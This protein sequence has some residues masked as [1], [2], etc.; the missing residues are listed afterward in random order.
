MQAVANLKT[1]LTR[2]N[3]EIEQVEYN[4]ATA[5]NPKIQDIC[6]KQLDKL[7]VEKEQILA[8][9]MEKD[10]EILNL[11]DYVSF[12]LGLKDNMLKLWKLATLT[13]KKSI[14]NL[15]F[16]EG[17]VYSK[18]NDDIEPLSKNEFLFLFDLKS[19]CC[20]DTKNGQTIISEDLSA[21]AP[22]LGLEPRTP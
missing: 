22:L 7:E 2:K 1:N 4:L 3:V 16:P 5:S 6:S 17:I 18:E 19:V 14:Q 13:N 8:E 9:L 10:K 20:G 15:I 21:S 11:N 12:G